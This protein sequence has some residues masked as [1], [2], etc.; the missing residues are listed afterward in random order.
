M[1]KTVLGVDEDLFT[2]QFFD[3]RR[4]KPQPGQVMARFTAVADFVGGRGKTDVI[5]LL[6]IDKAFQA[7]Q[8][9]KKI[10]CAREPD[11]YRVLREMCEDLQHMSEEEVENKPYRFILEAFFYTDRQYV[12][13]DDPHWQMIDLIRWDKDQNQFVSK[14]EV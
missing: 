11:C 5:Y 10:H 12:P 6:K 3:V 8:V 1:S 13:K 14:I 7:A 4:H 2:E 9:M